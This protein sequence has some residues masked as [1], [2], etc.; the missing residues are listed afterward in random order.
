MTRIGSSN[1]PSKQST[2][3]LLSPGIIRSVPSKTRVRPVARVR[4]RAVARVRTRAV[5]RV[6]TGQ[7]L[8]LGPGQ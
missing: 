5:A 2:G 1:V 6:R 4:T 3:W 7:W 8:G